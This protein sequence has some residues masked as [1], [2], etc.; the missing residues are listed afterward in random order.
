M[1][2]LLLKAF[3][4]N[5]NILHIQPLKHKLQKLPRKFVY[6]NRDQ[7]NKQV[8]LVEEPVPSTLQYSQ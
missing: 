5:K 2:K 3:P 1:V 4:L 6:F 7:S 8:Y